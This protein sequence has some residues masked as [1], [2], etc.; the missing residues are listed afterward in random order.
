MNR[1][2]NNV[3]YKVVKLG[4]DYIFNKKS[5][6]KVKDILNRQ[7]SISMNQIISSLFNYNKQNLLKSSAV[8]VLYLLL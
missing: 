3:V 5:G 7:V 2:K 1:L 6:N 4:I 8:L